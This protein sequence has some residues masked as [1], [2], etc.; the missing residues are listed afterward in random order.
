M[1]VTGVKNKILRTKNFKSKTTMNLDRQLEISKLNRLLS[2]LYFEKDENEVQYSWFTWCVKA[3]LLEEIFD[4][5]F[6]K[7]GKHILKHFN[8]P[9]VETVEDINIYFLEIYN[10]HHPIRNNIETMDSIQEV[11]EYVNLNS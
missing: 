8:V 10:V 5:E 1:F 6:I 4:T 2:I 9:K 11:R 3:L 7:A